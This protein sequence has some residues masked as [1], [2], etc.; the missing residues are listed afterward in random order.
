MV[1][2][3]EVKQSRC[4]AQHS[5]PHSGEVKNGWSY[6]STPHTCL[7]GVHRGSFTFAF[8]AKKC[9]QLPRWRMSFI[10]KSRYKKFSSYFIKNTARVHCKYLWFTPV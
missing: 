6:V 5:L 7:R 4:E 8:N 3:R 10:S 2:L 1:I 9:I